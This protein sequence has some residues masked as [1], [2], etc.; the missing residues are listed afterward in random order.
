MTDDPFAPAQLVKIQYN[1]NDLNT[2]GSFTMV[3][4]RAQMFKAL[5]A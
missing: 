4:S 3:T 2:K 5:L 1:F